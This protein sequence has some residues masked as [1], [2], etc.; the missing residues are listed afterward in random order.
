MKSECIICSKLLMEEYMFRTT[1]GMICTKCIK[2]NMGISDD[3]FI[4]QLSAVIDIN[5]H[6]EDY[7]KFHG[8][9]E[10][11]MTLEK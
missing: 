5:T 3:C 10:V 7:L 2:S 8:S 11:S 9:S 4:K 6:Y 1:K